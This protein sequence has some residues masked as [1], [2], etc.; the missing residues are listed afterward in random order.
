MS[1]TKEQ[2]KHTPGPW[3][4]DEYG[5]EFTMRTVRGK[6]LGGGTEVAIITTG[7]YSD[8]VEEANARLIAA[9]PELLEACKQAE[10][11]YEQLGD[12]RAIKMLRA[13][14]AKAEAS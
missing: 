7:S 9:A 8:E 1:E 11:Q 10:W 6:S 14:I 3:I 4:L 5:P 13:A 2:A 12:S